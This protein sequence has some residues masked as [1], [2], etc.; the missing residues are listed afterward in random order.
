MPL[1]FMI[2]CFRPEVKQ[3][4]AGNIVDASRLS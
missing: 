1:H 2:H 3:A 4:S